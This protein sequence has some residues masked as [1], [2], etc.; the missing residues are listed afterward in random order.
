MQMD[1]T[2]RIQEESLRITEEAAVLNEGTDPLSLPK[3]TQIQ[4]CRRF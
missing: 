1:V 4:T 2:M 3:A